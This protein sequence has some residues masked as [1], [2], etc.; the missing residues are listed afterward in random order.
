[1]LLATPDITFPARLKVLRDPNVWIADTGASCNSTGHHV[2]MVNQKV[3][4]KCGGVTL[5]DG[6]VKG[7][8]MVGDIHG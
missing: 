3:A 7:A 8:P 6:S 4:P 1:M 5:P 2:H